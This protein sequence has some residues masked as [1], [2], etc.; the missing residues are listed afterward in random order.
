MDVLHNS[1]PAH[2][3]QWENHWHYL[4]PISFSLCLGL[5]GANTALSVL[6]TVAFSPQCIQ[7]DHKPIFPL[8]YYMMNK[9]G[10]CVDKSLNWQIAAPSTVSSPG[11]LGFPG[12]G[13][14]SVSE[15]PRYVCPG[16]SVLKRQV[17][18]TEVF[19]ASHSLSCPSD[20]VYLK[21]VCAELLL[22][23]ATQLWQAE[24]NV[25][26]YYYSKL[27]TM[28]AQ[29]PLHSVFIWHTDKTASD[30]SV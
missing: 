14:A 24:L 9:Q 6:K 7:V 8:N 22:R 19:T 10:F 1:I 2:K 26:L 28:A 18:R 29:K 23:T 5:P 30:I 27:Y 3:E 15:G 21:G 4:T 13:R 16:F 25:A 20:K 11:W 17:W 12:G